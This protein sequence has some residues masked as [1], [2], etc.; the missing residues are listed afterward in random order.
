VVAISTQ[1]D[2]RTAGLCLRQATFDFLT[3][4]VERLVP[5]LSPEGAPSWRV[6]IMTDRETGK[7]RP[8][9]EFDDF[10]RHPGDRE[11]VAGAVIRSGPD[12]ALRA[13]PP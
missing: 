3:K 1:T 9:E 12:R 2:A 4:P 7:P 13:W 8:A 6:R 5:L 10:K 11:P